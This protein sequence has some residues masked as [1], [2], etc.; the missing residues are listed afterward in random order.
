MSCTGHTYARVAAADTGCQTCPGYGQSGSRLWCLWTSPAEPNLCAGPNTVIYKSL[1]MWPLESPSSSATPPPK[2]SVVVGC[3]AELS[4]DVG[5]TA[6][7]RRRITAA[8]GRRKTESL[9]NMRAAEGWQH[10]RGVCKW[11]SSCTNCHATFT[12]VSLDN[13]QRGRDCWRTRWSTSTK[14]NRR[15]EQPTFGFPGLY[16]VHTEG[17]VSDSSKPAGALSRCG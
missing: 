2:I 5:C 10:E 9:G 17:Y 1:A 13:N 11:L 14:H 12:M 16:R 3:T 15:E 6:A 8:A 4:G 7:G